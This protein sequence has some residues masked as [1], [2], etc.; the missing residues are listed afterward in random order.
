MK[1]S[2]WKEE[3]RKRIEKYKSATLLTAGMLDEAEAQYIEMANGGDGTVA[4][5]G[6]I[7]K[8][9]YDG[10]PDEFFQYVCHEMGWKWSQA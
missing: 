3:A 1:Y 4:M 8:E 10:K 5:Q 6:N 9:Y 7:R 2:E